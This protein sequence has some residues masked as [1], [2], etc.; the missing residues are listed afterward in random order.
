MPWLDVGDARKLGQFVSAAQKLT[1]QLQATPRPLDLDTNKEQRALVA[2]SKLFD[3]YKNLVTHQTM[4]SSL[5]M[6]DPRLK[7]AWL[8]EN[9]EICLPEI[10]AVLKASIHEQDASLALD[11]HSFVGHLDIKLRE[12]KSIAET[13]PWMHLPLD[14]KG[15]RHPSHQDDR[16]ASLMRELKILAPSLQTIKT[17]QLFYGEERRKRFIDFWDRFTD[18]QSLLLTLPYEN[19]LEKLNYYLDLLRMFRGEYVEIKEEY[20]YGLHLVFQDNASLFPGISALY[21]HYISEL[22]EPAE[23]ILEELKTHR[24]VLMGQLEMQIKARVSELSQ[25]ETLNP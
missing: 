2:S 5:M 13:A 6:E 3:F 16:I 1:E 19:D 7:Q 11:T 9:Q 21:Q 8:H 23:T 17:G 4:P 12:H 14:A 10:V 18:A 15:E 24:T 25:V 20:D 22:R